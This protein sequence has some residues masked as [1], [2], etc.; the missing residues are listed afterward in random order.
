MHDH[1]PEIHQNPL[2]SRRSLDI[3]GRQPFA[4]EDGVNM[5]SD[6]LDL[7]LGLS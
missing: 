1:V 2:G 4:R 3:H 5:V 6:G 7:A